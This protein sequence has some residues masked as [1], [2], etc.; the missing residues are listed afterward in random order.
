MTQHRMSPHARARHDF[1]GSLYREECPLCGAAPF[2]WCQNKQ[3]GKPCSIPH[4]V[5]R[6]RAV[7]IS[8]GRIPRL[9]R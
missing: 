5:R 8:N 1:E 9:A 2:C 6:G 7:P 4:A 3:S